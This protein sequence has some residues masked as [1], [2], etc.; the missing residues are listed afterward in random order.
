M[1][2]M[3]ISPAYMD[4]VYCDIDTTSCSNTNANQ[5]YNSFQQTLFTCLIGVVNPIVGRQYSYDSLKCQDQGFEE[6]Q[7]QYVSRLGFDGAEFYYSV[8]EYIY[9]TY[10]C[11]CK[12]ASTLY[13]SISD[14][15]IQQAMKTEKDNF[16]ATF[17][18]FAG[19]D[20]IEWSEFLDCNI[21]KIQCDLDSGKV[22][23]VPKECGAGSV[24]Y[25][26]WFT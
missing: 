6:V 15:S 11:A 9:Y 26:Q 25:S 13:N 20:P 4:V 2:K 5:I 12:T 17:A 16:I 14:T 10:E 21:G 3:T 1:S 18:R 23:P 22:V 7:C 19:Q 24:L 8:N